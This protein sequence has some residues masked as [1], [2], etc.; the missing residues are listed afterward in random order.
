ML[1]S[2]QLV[3]APPVSAGVYQENGVMTGKCF[4]YW[5]GCVICT[6][7]QARRQMFYYHSPALV[8]LNG[9]GPHNSDCFHD[10]VDN[11]ILHFMPLHTSD[12]MQPLDLG[13]FAIQKRFMSSYVLN[14]KYSDKTQRLIE[15]LVFIER[16]CVLLVV[17]GA[18][19]KQASAK[20]ILNETPMGICRKV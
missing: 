5:C 8:I 13:G 6:A 18:F 4:D 14:R 11:V 7:L 1:S 2:L 15:I 3:T 16:A 17:I 20:I 19:R 12:Q 9:F 10:P